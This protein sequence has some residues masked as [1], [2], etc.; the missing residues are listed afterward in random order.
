MSK[1]KPIIFLTIFSLWIINCSAAD[2]NRQEKEIIIQNIDDGIT[3][4]LVIT[5][6]DKDERKE[7]E[8][9]EG[10]KVMHVIEESNAEKAGL[11]KNDVIV[12]FEGEKIEDAK[13][14]NDLVEA[15]ESEKDVNM[16][17]LRNGSKQNIS[18]TIKPG[19]E[20]HSVHLKVVGEGDG[21]S[22]SWST[23]EADGDDDALVWV[24]EEDGEHKVIIK[25][26][27]GMSGTHDISVGLGS[28]K[29]KGGFLGVMT[30]NISKQML[31]YF[32]VDHGVL[33]KEI[34]EDS[35]AEKA[36]LKAGDVITFIEDRKI[37]DY[38][39]LIRTISFYNPEEEIEVSYVRKGSKDNVDVKLDKKKHRMSTVHGKGGHSFFFSDDDSEVHAPRF[40][41]NKKFKGKPFLFKSV[42]SGDHKMNI[43]II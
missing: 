9:T 11:K 37:E 32:E 6:L 26:F 40:K 39:D 17:V 35:P 2:G 7:L 16:A 28:G 43:Y 19:D 24:G 41:M 12:E 29:S 22:W 4:G 18:A 3:L 8:I 42:G 27:G 21:E 10:A 13:E 5:D 1:F 34:V 38:R 23:S 30:D 25:E 36:G 33:I 20:D 14:L 31:E 15:I